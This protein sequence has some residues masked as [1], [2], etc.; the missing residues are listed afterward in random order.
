MTDAATQKPI[1][2]STDGTAGPYIMTPLSQLDKLRRLLESHDVYY[3]VEEEAI[4]FNGAPA[5]AVVDLGRGGDAAAVQKIL[6]STK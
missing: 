5:I 4:S 3:W 6:D 2:V 1:V